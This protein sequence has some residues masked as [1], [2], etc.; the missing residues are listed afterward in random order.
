MI[1]SCAVCMIALPVSK[2]RRSLNSAAFSSSK[3]VVEYLAAVSPELELANG[4]VCKT[5]PI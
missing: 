3:T 2:Q 4:S 5:A 1:P